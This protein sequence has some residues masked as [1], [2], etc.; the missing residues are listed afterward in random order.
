[1]EHQDLKHVVWR[2]NTNTSKRNHNPPGTAAFHKLD[3][4]EPEPPPSI[5]HSVKVK[6]QKG[7]SAKKMTQ[8][9]L[10][11]QLNVP[12]NTISSYESGKAIPNKALLRKI[13]NV[14]GIKL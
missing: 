4:D 6:I 13:Q 10:A 8:K 3:G 14:L 9:Q 1:M 12:V 5:E 2:K 7:R 11:M